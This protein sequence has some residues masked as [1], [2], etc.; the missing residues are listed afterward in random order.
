MKPYYYRKIFSIVSALLIFGQEALSQKNG[1]E[2]SNGILYLN[3]KIPNDR[4][5]VLQ[6]MMYQRDFSN[7]KSF[8]EI[9]KEV[10]THQFEGDLK[11]FKDKNLWM[12]LTIKN[13]HQKDT[14]TSKLHFG[15]R[16]V[17]D[18]YE[19]KDAGITKRNL[20]WRKKNEESLSK[21]FVE[22]PIKIAPQQTITYWLKS[23]QFIN[24]SYFS[25]ELFSESIKKEY[26]N[27]PDTLLFAFLCL[28]TGV[29][30]FMG[31]FALVQSIYN[32]DSTYGYWSIYLLVNAFLFF[33]ELDHLYC[34]TIIQ[35][36][37]G[38]LYYHPWSV[39]GHFLVSMAYILFLNSF[40]RIKEYNSKIYRY[41]KRVISFIF[42]GFVFAFFAVSK[43]ELNLTNFAGALVLVTNLLILILII[44]ILRADIPQKKLILI[45]TFGVLLG[46]T[47]GVC[48]EVFE[49]KNMAV[50]LSVPIVFYAIGTIWELAL[51]SLALSERTKLLQ[52]ENQTL[53]Q[54]YTKNL[55]SELSKQ[56]VEINNKNKLI[57]NQ[58]IAQLTN[59]F[60]NKIAET[61]ISALRSQMNPHFI[62]N[63]LNSIKLYS[64]ENDSKAASDYLTKFSRLI[65]LVLENSRSEKVTLENE[66][67]TLQ[68]YIEM[69]AMRFKDKVKF[70]FNI[71]KEIDQ[72]FIDIP[73]LL[74][75]PFVENAIW[76]GLMHKEAG[77]T[78]WVNIALKTEN[79][80]HIE[81]IDD[82]V[83]R[84]KSAEY[85][86]KSATRNKSFGMK[87]TSERIELINQIYKT[88]TQIEIIDL[89]DSNNN[90][91]GT[92]V[93]LN[94]PI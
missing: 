26:N 18:V 78:I 70:Y 75:Q 85:K 53:Q 47:I 8:N 71:A 16:K 55:E 59:E 60:E 1:A 37:K 36:L 20:I 3:G 83:G 65:R 40:L 27:E 92:K 12:R 51:F 57:E 80:L 2:E 4:L 50:F 93:I 88:N 15:E 13:T 87:V 21:E 42:I 44:K 66:L 34:L 52:A 63:C 25:P 23:T 31:I 91:N 24:F 72:Q 61:E 67:A 33:A 11:K 84:A 86:S 56:S 69:E 41:M 89:K 17:A 82:G 46:A 29:C 28:I 38:E 54:Q 81:I 48:L 14:V 5:S 58:K 73:P 43:Y 64:L 19:K 49:L 79:L 22:I 76:H 45:G 30:F 77:G 94:I 7:A 62:F 6:F 32:K 68:L 39:P 35:N 74:L 10:F 90:P 9:S